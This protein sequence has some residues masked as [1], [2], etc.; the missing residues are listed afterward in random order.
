MKEIK[1]ALNII[2]NR[3][4]S[5]FKIIGSHRSLKKGKIDTVCARSVD[6]IE[7][8]SEAVKPTVNRV[9]IIEESRQRR[10]KFFENSATQAMSR[11]DTI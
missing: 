8:L 2:L 10:G 6:L 5:D 4:Y 3:M 11:L 7:I 1:K 9:H